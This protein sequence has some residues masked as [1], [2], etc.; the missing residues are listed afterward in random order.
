M[1]S[2]RWPEGG[3][4]ALAEIATVCPYCGCGCGLYL[5]VREGLVVGVSP[6]RSHPISQ[7]RLCVKG[8][9]AHEV[10]GNPNRL[11]HPL[12]RRGDQL[13][14][15]SWEE[16]TDAVARGLAKVLESEGPEAIGVLGSAR[17]TNEDNYVLVRFARGSL[18]TANIDSSQR[19]Q[20][21]PESA[22]TGGAPRP[23]VDAG[24]IEDLD[25]SDLILL[26]GS[27][28]TE[29]H[30]AVAA[31]IYR[32]RQ[33]GARVIAVSARKHP[34][35]RLA[36]VH[37]AVRPGAELQWIAGL[38]HILLVEGEMA[39]DADISGLAALRASVADLG[40]EET[41][42][43]T[44]VPAEALRG[45][46]R[47]YLDAKQVAVLYSAGLALSPQA[48]A[49][50]Q[51][52]ASLAV[53]GSSGAGP[54]VSVL[55]LLGRNNLQGCRDMGVA[56][57]MLPGYAALDDD[58]ARE[59]FQ[60]PW[61]CELPRE[62]GLS[63]WQMLGRVR[64]LYVMGDDVTRSLPDVEATRA[65]LDG[66]DFLVVQDIFM[67]ETAQIADVVLPAASF[68]ERDGTWTNLEGRVQ[69]IRRAVDPPGG[70]REDW[71]IIAD[72]SR[73]MGKP[74]PYTSAEQ[75]LEEIS[76]L[77]PIYA[78]VSYPPLAVN[79][80]IRWPTPE[81]RGAGATAGSPEAASVAALPADAL[82]TG[83]GEAA[84]SEQ[85]PLLMAADPTLRPW[86]GEVTV[87]HTLT[88]AGEFTVIARDYPDGMLCLNPED[89][90]RFD[91]RAGRAAR[92]ASSK[93]EGQMQVRVTDEAPPGIA[94]V[95]Y[96]QA[97]R[98]GLMEISIE[99]AT[100]R[101]VL[102]PTPIS[103]GPVQ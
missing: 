97:M 48:G 73:Q 23:A 55:G 41:Q 101:P 30:P 43:A 22:R 52:L 29:E 94:L 18:G 38:L 31:R 49:A 83:G 64:A 75:I 56:P 68:A 1:Y 71:R 62:A 98:S 79:G 81:A 5:H 40:P 63:A 60:R 99:P 90:K 61:Q 77:V 47:L 76:E 26:V 32:A 19:I 6:S 87:C 24:R 103:V 92:V 34:L 12:L 21:A 66:L 4:R 36:D 86:D 53:L 102:A 100:G 96:D 50:A 93:G 28:P 7:G 35:A 59:R 17:C 39:G 25:A 95:P 84:T 51:A 20:Y 89:A 88:A 33:R 27:D 72:V 9:H 16:A 65:A 69:R 57:D 80:G 15:A 70:A 13:V 3:A 11:T 82:K 10:V 8:W 85:Y 44:N 46:A 91:V 58:A 67:H 37:L 14:E 54:Q 45:A 2:L 42:K 74:L 78:G